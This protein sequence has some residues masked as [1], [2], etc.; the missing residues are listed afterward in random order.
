M[1]QFTADIDSRIT[2]LLDQLEAPYLSEDREKR[3]REQ[4]EYL[5]SQVVGT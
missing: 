4:V 1:P 3:L 2:R 5:Q